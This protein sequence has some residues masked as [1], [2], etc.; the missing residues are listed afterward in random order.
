MSKQGKQSDDEHTLRDILGRAAVDAATR[1]IADPSTPKQLAD[2]AMDFVMRAAR[3]QAELP[4]RGSV[5]V[6]DLI[7]LQLTNRAIFH[8][9]DQTPHV[10]R[11]REALGPFES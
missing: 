3:G 2:L 1:L 7:R 5:A 10:V 8:P 6:V 9:E 4:A 11:V